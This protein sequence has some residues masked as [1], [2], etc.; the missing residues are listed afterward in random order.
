M[1]A[2]ICKMFEIGLELLMEIK[3]VV[4]E[5]VTVFNVFLDVI[6]NHLRWLHQLALIL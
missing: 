6:L 4:L 3:S 1:I 2:Y 5:T